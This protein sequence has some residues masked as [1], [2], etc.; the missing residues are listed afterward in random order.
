MKKIFALVFTAVLATG[1][2]AC[3]PSDEEKKTADSLTDAKM[4]SENDN[5]ADSIFKAMEQMNNAD[6]GKK[7]DSVK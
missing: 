2:I 5:I 6:T 4:K 7:N 1:F 3:G